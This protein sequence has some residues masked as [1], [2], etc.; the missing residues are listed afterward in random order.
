[1][2]CRLVSR[3]RDRG[4]SRGKK[5]VGRV[6]VKRWRKWRD[7]RGEACGGCVDELSQVNEHL[8]VRPEVGLRAQVRDSLEE[9]G[10]LKGGQGIR[11]DGVFK[12]YGAS[13]Q[14]GQVMS[15]SGLSHE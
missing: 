8:L 13:E 5:G 4:E 9:R 1:M 3:A 11:E 14:G 6:R 7:P 12:D 10:S 15:G 2:G